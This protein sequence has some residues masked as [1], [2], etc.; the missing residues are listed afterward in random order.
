MGFLLLGV[1][2]LIACIAVGPIVSRRLFVPFAA[3]FGICDAGGFLLGSALHW[4][5]PASISAMTQ[6]AILVALGVYWIA[7]AAAPRTAA[8]KTA[9]ATPVPRSR[10]LMWVLP[11]AL[12][13]DNIAYGLIGGRG[14]ILQQAGQQ[15]LSSA[16]LGGMGLAIGLAVASAIPA[17]RRHAAAANGVAGGALIVASG[18]LLLWG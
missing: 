12:S 6:T 1:D 18:A 17:V 10:W 13:I 15:A 2:S 3:L 7:V 14:A 9:R 5:V 4:S 11:F 8:P 16:L